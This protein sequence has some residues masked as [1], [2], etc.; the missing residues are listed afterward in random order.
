MRSIRTI[1]ARLSFTACHS[2]DNGDAASIMIDH[3]LLTQMHRWTGN[4][5]SLSNPS[6]TY[7]MKSIRSM[8]VTDSANIA[9]PI[10]LSEKSDANNFTFVQDD[11]LSSRDPRDAL[12][13]LKYWLTVVRIT[14]TDSASAGEALSA[15][16]T[17]YS[18]TYI[19]LY[20][21]R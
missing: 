9:Q 3:S 13:Q 21:H 2:S 17:F 15:I 12:Y 16:A 14:Q 18:A 11:Q 1:L 19:V 8:T 6:S 7:V 20:T 5:T 10:R 4:R